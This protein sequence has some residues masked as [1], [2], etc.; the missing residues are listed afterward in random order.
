MIEDTNCFWSYLVA[1][2]V[3]LILNIIETSNTS[4]R[5]P[6]RTFTLCIISKKYSLVTCFYDFWAYTIYFQIRNKIWAHYFASLIRHGLR[7]ASWCYIECK[8]VLRIL[9]LPKLTNFDFKKIFW[10]FFRGNLLRNICAGISWYKK[11]CLIFIGY[12]I[13]IRNFIFSS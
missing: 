7:M 11:N 2:N 4:F 3:F 8:F 1:K 6:S 5:S 13:F 9:L 10:Y 12:T